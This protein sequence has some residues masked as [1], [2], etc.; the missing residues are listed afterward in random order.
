MQTT[1]PLERVNDEVFIASEETVCL[2]TRAVAF[3]RECAARNLR[4]RARIC[5]HKKATDT[6]HEMLIAI[7]SA[8]YV[9]PHRHLSKSESFHLVEGAADVVIFGEDGGIQR[10]VELGPDRN[11]FYRLDTPRYH[12]LV[13]NSPVV[14]IHEVTNGPFDPSRSDVAAFAPS[15]GDPAAAAYVQSLKLQIQRWKDAAAPPGSE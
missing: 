8:S 6:L 9:R 15:E 10:V 7:T 2:D 5:A 4:G 13:V 11:F 12:T 14:V 3:V 1:L